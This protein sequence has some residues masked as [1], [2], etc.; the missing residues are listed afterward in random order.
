MPSS[1]P[2]GTMQGQREAYKRRKH[3]PEGSA[4]TCRYRSRRRWC[5]WQPLD[6][7]KMELAVAAAAW[8]LRWEEAGRPQGRKTCGRRHRWR[9]FDL[10]VGK[11]SL[12]QVLARGRGG[13]RKASAGNR[14]I[15]AW[16]SRSGDQQHLGSSDFPERGGVG[17]RKN[18]P[19]E[20]KR[21]TNT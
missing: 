17:R 5:T 15:W 13:G 8:V 9:P 6:Q 12:D 7:E 10:H 3:V 11:S 21:R 16:R 4:W 1:I 19:E 14:Y 2:Q 18:S 20:E